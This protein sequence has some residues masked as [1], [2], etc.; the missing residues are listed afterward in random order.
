MIL[1]VNQSTTKEEEEEAWCFV[2]LHS[3]SGSGHSWAVAQLYG[4]VGG[5]S[6]AYIATD[7]GMTL[8]GGP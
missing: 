4:R 1:K 5:P 8:E 3:S 6:E 7:T 2:V